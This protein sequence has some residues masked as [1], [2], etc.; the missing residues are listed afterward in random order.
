MSTDAAQPGRTTILAPAELPHLGEGTPAER[1]ARVEAFLEVLGDRL[2]ELLE[3]VQ[4]LRR[5]RERALQVTVGAA[6]AVALAVVAL[7][8]AA[9]LALLRPG[10][11]WPLTV[12]AAI[13]AGTLTVGSIR[14]GDLVV[15]AAH[16]V[17]D[18]EEAREHLRSAP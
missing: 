8:Q 14:Y 17:I 18:T 6:Q 4:A 13:L 9:L 1:L 15:E 5:S 11:L 7:C 16:E 12:L 3:E 10:T 2:D